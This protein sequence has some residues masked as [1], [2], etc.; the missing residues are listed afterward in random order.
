M[1][2]DRSSQIECGQTMN[3]LPALIAKAKAHQEN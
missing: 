1:N 2:V 3:Q